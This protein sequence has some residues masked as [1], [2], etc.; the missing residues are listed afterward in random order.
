MQESQ[1]LI[2]RARALITKLTGERFT[3][4]DLIDLS[5]YGI[6]TGNK[7]P[8]GHNEEDPEETP[9]ET[10]GELE[11]KIEENEIPFETIRKHNIP[12]A[13]TRVA[14]EGVNGYERVKVFY[15]DGKE[16]KRE[17][18]EKENP[19]NE[20]IETYV[21]VKDEVYETKTV[22]DKSKPI[23]EKQYKEKYWFKGEIEATGEPLDLTFDT[24]EEAYNLYASGD[25]LGSWGGPI[26]VEEDVLVGYETTTENVKVADAVYAWE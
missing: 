2:I 4:D 18:L 1:D 15:K 5:K 22:E 19:V 14:Q 20:I 11:E 9:G 12:G 7:R 25:V 13:K 21:K 10:E 23:Y 16:V 24:Q 17:V 8:V 6:Y 26:E 3:N